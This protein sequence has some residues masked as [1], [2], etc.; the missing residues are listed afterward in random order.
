[1]ETQACAPLPV[2]K[3]K[4]LK[5]KLKTQ[6]TFDA[7]DWKSL[8]QTNIMDFCLKKWD[9]NGMP[10]CWESGYMPYIKMQQELDKSIIVS[11]ETMSLLLNKRSISAHG[12]KFWEDFAASLEDTNF[13]IVVIITY[14]NFFDW[15]YSYYTEK[16]KHFLRPLMRVWPSKGTGRDIPT[17]EEYVATNMKSTR[18]RRRFFPDNLFEKFSFRKM[19]SSRIS[20]KIINMD[21]SE[22]VKEEFFCNGLPSSLHMCSLIDKVIQPEKNKAPDYL[23]CD[24]LATDAYKNGLI[25]SKIK[26]GT[27]FE[28]IKKYQEELGFGC[29][30]F[31]AS[32]PSDE[33]YEQLFQ[34][35]MELHLKIFPDDIDDDDSVR[36]EYREK[37]EAKKYKFCTLNSTAVFEDKQW[38][39]FFRNL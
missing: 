11:K 15:I 6:N 25:D 30:D 31:P 13:H 27:V 34:T 14:R 20:V 7:D 19:N 32:C 9:R 28:R 24:M 21:K 39:A 35:S 26:R 22:D 8:S 12:D 5:K 38:E 29:S 1:M 33:F 18:D 2:G 4:A 3:S 37:F 23:W 17:P 16:N 36:R 10:K